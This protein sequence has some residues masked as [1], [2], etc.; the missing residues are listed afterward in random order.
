MSGGGG[1]GGGLGLQLRTCL[2]IECL[3]VRIAAG[4]FGRAGGV[5]VVASGEGSG[6]V[7]RGVAGAAAGVGTGVLAGEQGD[8][9]GEGEREEAER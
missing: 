7:R 8:W 3:L 9:G 6:D 4:A 2:S 1:G 5:E